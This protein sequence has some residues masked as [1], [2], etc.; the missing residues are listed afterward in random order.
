MMLR[1]W[2][3][4]PLCMDVGNIDGDQGENSEWGVRVARGGWT[5]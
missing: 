5:W 4:M 1:R 2:D 3:F